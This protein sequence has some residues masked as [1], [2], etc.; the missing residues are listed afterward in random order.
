MKLKSD[1]CSIN[2]CLR[3]LYKK[4]NVPIIQLG[5][6]RG[7]DFSIKYKRA[8]VYGTSF[9]L[10][11]RTTAHSFLYKETQGMSYRLGKEL[12][13]SQERSAGPR[14]MPLFAGMRYNGNSV[15]PPVDERMIPFF[16]RNQTNRCGPHLDLKDPQPLFRFLR[17]CLWYSDPAAIHAIARNANHF[18]CFWVLSVLAVAMS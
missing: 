6:F 11:P 16:G 17:L 12:V 18:W 5:I 2:P 1:W 15:S 14:G 10:K 8:T 4:H 3:L 9:T 7:S 13:S